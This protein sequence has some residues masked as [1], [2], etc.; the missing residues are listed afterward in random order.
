M[1]DGSL[2]R[3]PACSV[4]RFLPRALLW[5]RDPL[6]T[7]W[8]LL[9]TVQPL[10]C[11][12]DGLSWAA[13]CRLCWLHPRMPGAD[14]GAAPR[15]CAGSFC[16]VQLPIFCSLLCSVP[17]VDFTTLVLRS[18]LSRAAWKVY[19]SHPALSLSQWFICLFH[20]HTDI[21]THAHTRTQT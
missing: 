9:A 6:L 15:S 20:P 18:A 17:H 8:P 1:S 3:C 5:P 14:V 19:S 2:L 21:H 13:A 11:M 10:S 12:C 4:T 7:P 16:A